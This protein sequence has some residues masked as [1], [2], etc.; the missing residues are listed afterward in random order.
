KGT[1][2]S[3]TALWTGL[4]TVWYCG[5]KS[6][7][8]CSSALSRAPVRWASSSVLP[9]RRRAVSAK[10]CCSRSVGVLVLINETPV[11]GPRGAHVPVDV[12]GDPFLLFYSEMSGEV[13][14][15]RPRGARRSADTAV[16]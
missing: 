10:L 6:R 12:G 1:L 9:L 5:L 11:R 15:K 7:S 4:L 3:Q 2:F 14:G 16:W 8:T 13:G